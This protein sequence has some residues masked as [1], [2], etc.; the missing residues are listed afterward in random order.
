[1]RQRGTDRSPRSDSK[2]QLGACFLS[3]VSSQPTQESGRPC[4][5]GISAL[6]SE[7]GM[8][9]GAPF[10]PSVAYLRAERTPRRTLSLRRPHLPYAAKASIFSPTV[11]LGEP[12]RA[13]GGRG[14][15]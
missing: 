11:Q 15:S 5:S 7:A 6:V 2:P 12:P 1:M 13:A 14:F 9:K 3:V 10:D 8:S 4:W